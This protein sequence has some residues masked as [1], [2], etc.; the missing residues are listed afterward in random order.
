MLGELDWQGG[1]VVSDV[2][3]PQKFL[4]PKRIL[5]YLRCQRALNGMCVCFTVVTLWQYM[6]FM[7]KYQWEQTFASFCET[8]VS[9]SRN[10]DMDAD[11]NTG[12]ELN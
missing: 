7:M 11:G 4:Y 10:D 6:T 12:P 1:C 3:E 2:D 5:T 9:H 8:G